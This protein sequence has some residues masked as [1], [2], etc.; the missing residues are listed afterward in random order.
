MKIRRQRK[1]TLEKVAKANSDSL[2]HLSRPP[3][4]PKLPD[5]DIYHSWAEASKIESLLA[6]RPKLQKEPPV[7]K[8]GRYDERYEGGRELNKWKRIYDHLLESSR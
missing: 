2:R 5:A 4:N 7:N 3:R 6:S 8:D 1:H